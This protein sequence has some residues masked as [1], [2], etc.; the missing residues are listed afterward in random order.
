MGVHMPVDY[1]G[2]TAMV[3]LNGDDEAILAEGY[4]SIC[5]KR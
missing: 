3:W 4:Q 2:R 1:E 5:D